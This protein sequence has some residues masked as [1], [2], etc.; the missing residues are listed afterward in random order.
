MKRLILL[1]LVALPLCGQFGGQ[2]PVFTL[3]PRDASSGNTGLL[4]FRELTANGL[5]TVS[6]KA[7]DS[8]AASIEIALWNALPASTGCVQ[9]VNLG[10]GVGELQATG[11]G[12][13]GGA[14]GPDGAVQLSDGAGAVK[15]VT[16]F[17]FNAAGP[18]F[19]I[20]GD[21]NSGTH[22][23]FTLTVADSGFFSR[24]AFWM[25]ASDNVHV[26]AESAISTG[27][28]VL[29]A[30]AGSGSKYSLTLPTAAAPSGT[31]NNFLKFTTGGVGT[32]DAI[33]ALDIEN[34][35]TPLT[36]RG[37]LNFLTTINAVDAISYTSLEVNM[38]AN[39]LWTGQQ[40]F[41][42]TDV[43]GVIVGSTPTSHVTNM[44]RGEFWTRVGTP[45]IRLDSDP[46]NAT[47]D[48]KLDLSGEDL[49]LTG[50]SVWMTFD[51]SALR[52]NPVNFAQFADITNKTVDF[53]MD[54]LFANNTT[55]DALQ[56]TNNAS[57]GGNTSLL[58][59]LGV[60]GNTTV[61]NLT[62]SGTCTGCG[63][64]GTPG[65]SDS[66]VQY[67][68]GGSFGGESTFIY[69][70][71][72][73]TLDVSNLLVDAL[74]IDTGMVLRGF[75]RTNQNVASG[76]PASPATDKIPVY[77]ISGTLINYIYLYP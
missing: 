42:G 46:T 34:N 6:L 48:W 5:D 31:G 69:N 60:T 12:C 51:R 16:G 71:A 22:Q 2:A 41:S 9:L 72:T 75:I 67:N 10:S 14:I 44:G 39:Y 40:V 38:G 32:W 33:A 30:G 4:R 23:Q 68:N 54:A 20:P 50:G 25:D 18:E 35:S 64:G 28:L 58:G 76:S 63:S 49:Q 7:S 73:N 3:Q 62:V 55:L 36:S 1:A 17:V 47:P 11:S 70:D 24:R 45:E 26:G 15:V 66:Y 56:V 53:Y 59:T 8:L 13:S 19:T 37:I 21:I 74:E 29:H 57:V 65:G 61:T 43:E 52:I 27:N 77:D